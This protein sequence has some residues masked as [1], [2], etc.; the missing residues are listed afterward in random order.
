MRL[1]ALAL[2]LVCLAA[3]A[4]YADAAESLSLEFAEAVAPGL[5]G[6]KGRKFI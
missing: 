5:V 4:P 6:L 1:S 2:V 3:A